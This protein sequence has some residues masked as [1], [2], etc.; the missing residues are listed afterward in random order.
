MEKQQIFFFGLP[1]IGGLLMFIYSY[2]FTADSKYKTYFFILSYTFIGII[3]FAIIDIVVL[4]YS[5]KDILLGR[6]LFMHFTPYI[7]CYSFI[8][9]ILLS[10]ISD[11]FYP[12]IQ[13]L[14]S[15]A[16][17]NKK[18]RTPKIK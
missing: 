13:P 10:I 2:E 7:V 3:V 18:F 5:V 6:V 16:K 8:I 14:I 15:K 11:I 12:I 1:I 4:D 17:V 9:A